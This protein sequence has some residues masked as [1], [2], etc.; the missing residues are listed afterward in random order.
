QARGALQLAQ[1]EAQCALQPLT[2]AFRIWQQVR[3]PYMV[4]R[5]RVLLAC[6]CEA[7]GDKDA[8][9]LERG[10]ARVEFVRL[11]AIPDLVALDAVEKKVAAGDPCHPLTARELQVLRLVATGKSNKAVAHELSLSGKT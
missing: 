7:L 4:A 5:L 3:A 1:G 2:Q 11:G 9:L 6:A 10:A 8:A